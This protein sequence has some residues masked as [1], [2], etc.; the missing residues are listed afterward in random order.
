MESTQQE[1]ERQNG[2]TGFSFPINQRWGKEINELQLLLQRT[3]LLR[4]TNLQIHT[5]RKRPSVQAGW[6]VE[7]RIAKTQLDRGLL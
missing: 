1:R 6:K 2:F 4:I 5:F 7:V 3:I